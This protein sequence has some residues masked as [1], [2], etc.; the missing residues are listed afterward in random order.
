[1]KKFEIKS[2]MIKLSSEPPSTIELED[3]ETIISVQYGGGSVLQP[4]LIYTIKEIR[5][6]GR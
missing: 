3:N 1:M 5:G 4:Y 6:Y 2:Y